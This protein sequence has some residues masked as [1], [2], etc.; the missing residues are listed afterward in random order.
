MRGYDLGY[1]LAQ[2]Q[3]TRS[4][5]AMKDSDIARQIAQDHNLSAMVD[6]TVDEKKETLDY[7][8]QSNQ[9]D[10]AF[11]QTRARRIGYEVFVTEKTLH[12]RAPK[13]EAEKVLTLNWERDLLEFHPRLSILGQSSEVNMRAW[14][15]ADQK[16][17][18]STAPVSQVNPMSGQWISQ[19]GGSLLKT[20]AVTQI[21]TPVRQV[22]EAD[23]IVKGQMN[24]IA[25]NFITGDGLCFG[26]P[27]I[28]AGKVVE[29]TG[30]GRRFSGLYYI[31]ST[32][33]TFS[34]Q[35]GYSTAFTFRRNAECLG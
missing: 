24:A 6:D 28:R 13:H 10:L 21:T 1:R 23:A 4:F 32:E 25:L 2:G 7:V 17:Q 30:L 14:N 22:A 20:P 35:D 12:F 11:L 29:F 31:V 27:Q 16:P 3:K 5:T 26:N 18:L 19:V 8:L 9:S 15:V 33:H 34:V